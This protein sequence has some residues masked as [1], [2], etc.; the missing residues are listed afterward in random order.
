M[1]VAAPPPCVVLFEGLGG[2][3]VSFGGAGKDPAILLPLVVPI[4]RQSTLERRSAF[5]E[6]GVL[7]AI[8]E[9][10]QPHTRKQKNYIFL[11]SCASRG[12]GHGQLLRRLTPMFMHISP[13]A[14]GCGGWLTDGP[15][16]AASSCQFLKA[17]PR[18]S[19]TAPQLV[20]QWCM[21][22]AIQGEGASL[23]TGVQLPP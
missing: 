7:A 18:G 2:A 3:L 21:S 15:S 5:G 4:L 1:L 22:L 9:T 17:P 19:R 20:P 10:R 23:S 6:R 12:V 13:G 11:E 16:S 8:L 14:A